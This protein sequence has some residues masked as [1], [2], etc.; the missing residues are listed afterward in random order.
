MKNAADLYTCDMFGS[1]PVGRPKKLYPK[2]AALR[3]REYRARKAVEIV[4]VT[5][6]IN[7]DWCGMTRTADCGICNESK[8]L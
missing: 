3:T 5:G 7:C 8:T 6:D 1:R 4:F 2:S